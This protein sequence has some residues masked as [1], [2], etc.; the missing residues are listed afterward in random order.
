MLYAAL[1]W[2]GLAV[3]SPPSAAI[4][5]IVVNVERVE[6]EAG[7]LGDTTLDIRID[8]RTAMPRGT[9]RMGSTPIGPLA[10]SLALQEEGARG[11]RLKGEHLRLAGGARS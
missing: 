3:L 10:M 6:S 7:V 1:I 2:A 5:R 8:S 11:L 9:L 4:D